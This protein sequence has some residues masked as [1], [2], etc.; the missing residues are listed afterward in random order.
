[1]IW[2][3]LA[4]APDICGE[5]PATGTT[6]ATVDGSV[7]STSDVVLTLA[8]SSLQVTLPQDEDGLW[9]FSIVA[10]KDVGGTGVADLLRTP[11]S[12][13]I[14]VRL[15][16]GTEGGWAVA[17]TG[18]GN[19]FGTGSSFSTTE[20]ASGGELWISSNEEGTLHGCYSFS[21][22]NDEESI[23]ILDGVFSAELGE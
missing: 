19:A 5:A 20:S 13:P 2:L 6:Q 23:S 17:Y 16:T 12:F 7:W 15:Q 18:P 11:E 1:M 3:L 4:C 22:A 14:E 8:G 10:Q 9:Y 21:A